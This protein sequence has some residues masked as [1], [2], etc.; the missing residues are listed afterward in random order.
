[1]AS[2][3]IAFATSEGQTARVADR[4]Q[5]TIESRAHEVTT[6]DVEQLPRSFSIDDFDAALVGAS[7]HASA[8]Q[9]SIKA[10]VTEHRP[11]LAAIPTAFFQVSL[12]S[13][14]EEGQDEAA[15]YV[16]SFIEETGWHP[17]R[18]A[19]FGGALRF[20]EYGFL[21]RLMM[22]QIVKRTMDELPEPDAAGDIE[23]TDWDEVEAFANDVAAF[24][25]AR[26]KEYEG[27]T[28]Q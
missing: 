17:D 28:S 8:H 2:V 18:I 26:M 11:S 13:A 1:M 23:F 14:T 7:I 15:A 27:G 10:F 4:L 9:S 20:S 21:K 6:V 5:A 19:R 25:E 12:S 16:E 3:L 24:V 22:Q